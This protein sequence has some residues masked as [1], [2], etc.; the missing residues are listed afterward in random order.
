LDQEPPDDAI[1]YRPD[2]KGTVAVT[3]MPI[4]QVALTVVGRHVGNQR[5]QNPNTM[6]WGELGSHQLF[7]A[8]VDVTAVDG[9]RMWVRGTNLTDANVQA[10]FSYPEAGRQLFVGASWTGP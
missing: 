5:F 3:L 4:P 8:R 9:L 2:Q 6:L 10:H 7:D 1:P